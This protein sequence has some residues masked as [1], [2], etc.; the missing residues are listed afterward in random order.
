MI[1]EINHLERLGALRAVPTDE[2]INGETFSRWNTQSNLPK[3]HKE[4][5]NPKLLTKWLLRQQ[6]QTPRQ[7]RL[8]LRAQQLQPRKRRQ[9]TL[10]IITDASWHGMGTTAFR[11]NELLHSARRRCEF[12]YSTRER[13]QL[14]PNQSAVATLL[15]AMKSLARQHTIVV[16]TDSAANLKMV[17]ELQTEHKQKGA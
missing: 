14:N 2:S 16:T 17:V 12:L 4:F 5:V 8:T 3:G 13:G 9:P 15:A 10:R 1:R 7:S 6:L 11:G